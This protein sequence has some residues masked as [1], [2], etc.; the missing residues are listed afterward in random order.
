MTH[1]E[2]AVNYFSQKLHCSPSF[3]QKWLRPQWKWWKGLLRRWG[4]DVLNAAFEYL[5]V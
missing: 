4:I 5:T 1:T 2:K 3:A